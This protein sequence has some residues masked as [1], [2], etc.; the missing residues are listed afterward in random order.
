[1]EK[2][3]VVTAIAGKE[4]NQNFVVVDVKENFVF[5][6][7]GKRLKYNKPKKKSAKHVQ[8]CSTKKFPAEH[9]LIKDEKVN[10]EI[11]NFLKNL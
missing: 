1:M 7:D 3:F 11:R 6:A 2:G 5:L 9:L 4:K 10:A 8:K